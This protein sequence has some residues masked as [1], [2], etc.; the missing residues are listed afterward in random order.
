MSII[1]QDTQPLSTTPDTVAS[2]EKTAHRFA[3]KR[4]RMLKLKTK[5]TAAPESPVVI[6]EEHGHAVPHSEK[7]FDH[8]DGGSTGEST[9]PRGVSVDSQP[10]AVEPAYHPDAKAPMP[11]PPPTLNDAARAREDETSGEFDNMKELFAGNAPLTNQQRL[12]AMQFFVTEGMG[13]YRK[14]IRRLKLRIATADSTTTASLPLEA[15][16]RGSSEQR[17]QASRPGTSVKM[18]PQ[19]SSSRLPTEH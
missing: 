5:A 17:S 1:V 6:C 14:S 7:D 13:D 3:N 2:K 16:T 18:L 19:P 10:A 9:P 8:S 12:R 11:A 15:A 4:K